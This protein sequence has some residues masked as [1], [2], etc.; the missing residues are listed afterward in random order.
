MY[1]NVSLE[2][3]D[4]NIAYIFKTIVVW[5]HHV[6]ERIN[7]LPGRKSTMINYKISC[8]CEGNIHGNH[9]RNVPLQWRHRGVMPSQWV[10]VYMISK[11]KSMRC[12]LNNDRGGH[13]LRLA[14]TSFLLRVTEG[15]LYEWMR[16]T[17][18][19]STSLTHCGLIWRQRT[20]ST[21]VLVIACCLA[22]PSHYLNQCWLHQ[23][24]PVT[25]IL[26]QFHKGCLNHQ[27]LKYVWQLHI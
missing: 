27:S 24:S 18:C 1:D 23:W 21:L 3:D 12:L 2:A 5:S 16:G 22:A 13:C 19:S 10:A 4:T 17:E 15:L 26:G 25:F 6:F 20:G 14:V 7:N 11:W 9:H 8:S